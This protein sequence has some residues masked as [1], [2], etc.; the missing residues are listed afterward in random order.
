MPNANSGVP[1]LHAADLDSQ[2]RSQ[3]SA[4]PPVQSVRQQQMHASACGDVHRIAQ[5][6]A[7]LQEVVPKL[8]KA[9]DRDRSQTH[10]PSTETA[11]ALLLVEDWSNTLQALLTHL[12]NWPAL[13]GSPYIARTVGQCLDAATPSA[14]K[15]LERSLTGNQ[16]IDQGMWDSALIHLQE[17]AL[18][19]CAACLDAT[20]RWSLLI[21]PE[22]CSLPSCQ[23]AAAILR[24]PLSL[25][26]SV[27]PNCWLP[28]KPLRQWLLLMCLRRSLRKPLDYTAAQKL[29][30]AIDCQAGDPMH[31][32]VKWR[33]PEAILLTIAP[34][35]TRF[36]FCLGHTLPLDGA[37]RWAI[38]WRALFAVL[39]QSG[40]AHQT[41]HLLDAW[42]ILSD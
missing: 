31:W 23:L 41:A 10:Q 38:P 15:L 6:L 7:H 36:D 1:A 42:Q 40:H 25:A 2:S 24:H 17:H 28:P 32:C 16:P 13:L 12:I 22:R 35:A 20:E 29:L 21:H 8:R 18:Q 3:D 14:C 9:G 27:S 19:Q 26:R 34:T 4:V 39:H 11:N 33:D 37:L 5:Q 30:Q